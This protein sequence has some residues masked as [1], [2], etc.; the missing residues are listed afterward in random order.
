MNSI[1]TFLKNLTFGKK[2]LTLSTPIITMIVS[3][4][5]A[6]LGLFLL[7]IIDLITGIRKNLHVKNIGYNPFNLDFYKSIKSYLLRKTWKKTYEYL[8]GIIALVIIES[9]VL[10]STPVEI[11]DKTFSLSELAVVFPAGVELWSI[12][13]NM[14][15]VSGNNILKKINKLIPIRVQNIFKK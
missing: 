10:N 7:I 3:M 14:E 8:I 2:I 9:L 6:L 12:F 5:A 13:E 4:D 15:A 11:S 1:I